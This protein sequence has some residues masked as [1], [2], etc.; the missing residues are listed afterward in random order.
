VASLGCTPAKPKVSEKSLIK[1]STC[2]MQMTVQEGLE[3]YETGHK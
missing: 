1:C 2:G 3:A